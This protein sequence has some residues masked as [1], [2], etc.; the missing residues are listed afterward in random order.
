MNCRSEYENGAPGTLR[1][2]RVA[3]ERACHHCE[4]RRP[5]QIDLLWTDTE[6]MGM[7]KWAM[8]LF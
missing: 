8:S 3:L 4:T 2:V 7:L 1:T 5:F 6:I